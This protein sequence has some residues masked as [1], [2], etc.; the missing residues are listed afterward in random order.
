[1]KYAKD[2]ARV[3]V[4]YENVGKMP[5]DGVFFTESTVATS[6][7]CST[8]PW[9]L[10]HSPNSWKNVGKVPSTPRPIRTSETTSARRV[11]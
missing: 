5:Q 10:D 1:V 4:V 9:C 3:V 2:A 11:S 8:V 6:N 7:S